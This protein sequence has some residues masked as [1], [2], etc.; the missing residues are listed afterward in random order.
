VN[1][2]AAAATG[3]SLSR[4]KFIALAGASA[5]AASVLAACGSDSSTG[6]TTG[7]ETAKFGDG[8][9][10]ILNYALTLEYVEAAF[11]AAL[12]TSDLLTAPAKETLGKFGE[13]EKEHVA[14]LA[15]EIEKLGGKSV[16]EPKTAFSLEDESEALEIGSTLENVIAAAY[17][18][19]L[20]WIKSDSALSLALAIHSVEG[21]H[22]AALNILREESGTPDG[23]FAEPATVA[24]VLEAIEPYVSGELGQ[25]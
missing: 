8:D 14:A 2:D 10:G 25:A 1:T 6:A 19:Q 21:R 18:G 23:A 11:Y 16:A 9:L 5:G 24:S 22:A 15:K 7:G 3:A 4:R 20:P 13:E 17:Q 12:T